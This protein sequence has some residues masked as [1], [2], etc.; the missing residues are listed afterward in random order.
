[1]VFVAEKK[2]GVNGVNKVCKLNARLVRM[3]KEGV[4]GVNGVNKVCKL[5]AR[6]VRMLKGGVN[7]GGK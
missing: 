4:N 3:L 7:E 2:E 6:L 5:N 1:M